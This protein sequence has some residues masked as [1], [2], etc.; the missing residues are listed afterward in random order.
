AADYIVDF[1]ADKGI[2]NVFMISGG[3][4]MHIIDAVGRSRRVKFLANLHEQACGFAAEGYARMK[5]APGA[6]IVTTG[7]G[8]TNALTP[9]INCWLDS[10]PVVFVSGQVKTENTI[11]R[12]KGLRQFGDQEINIVDMAKPVSKYAVM[13]TD[14]SKLKYEMEK[15]FYTAVSGRPGPVWVDVPLDIQASEFNPDDY[16]GFIPKAEKKPAI[17]NKTARIIKK[18]EMSER[19]LIIAGQGIRLSGALKSFLRLAE[20]TGIPVV[21]SILGKD[22]LPYDHP[23]CTG[24][25]GIAG[26][27][28]ANFA[29]AN[30]DF[31]LSLGSRL[32]LRQIGFNYKDFAKAAY[33]AVVDIDGN[34]ARKKS[35]S[36]DMPIECDAGI[37]IE[38]MLAL[39]KHKKDFGEKYA[40]WRARCREWHLKYNTAEKKF[41]NQKKFI[42]SHIFAERFSEMSKPG[43][44]VVTANGTSYIAVLQG[45]KVKENQRLIYNKASAPMGYGLS[46]AIGAC[47]ANNKRPV[48]CFENDGSLQMNIQELQTIAGHKI[49]VK[50]IVFNNDGYLSIKITQK[51]FF[52]DNFTACNPCSGVILPELKKLC[53]AYGIPYSAL[54]EK[55]KTESA[56]KE[57]MKKKGPAVMEVFMD[58]WQEFL[59]KA[60]S[61]MRKDG[62]MEAKPLEDMYP[63][64]ERK[65]FKRNII[66][67]KMKRK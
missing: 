41:K 57:F 2:K 42:N 44:V 52:S 23:L 38:E 35:V 1:L 25:P 67:D 12:H 11:F 3:G 8:G 36:A 66:T 55:R 15:A 53:S 54:S 16:E 26:Q 9:L 14:K 20:K 31:I 48:Y 29:C 18:M 32:M 19:P 63:F 56:I 61:V 7:P 51:A 28:G 30:A 43:D 65:E 60:V 24:L 17:K 40:P 13:V 50:V 49:P 6:C 34:E 10:V 59:P 45:Y 64:L 5:N 33:K 27:R 58:P 46:A 39:L 4:V 47:I 21:T 37:F 62:V 22:I